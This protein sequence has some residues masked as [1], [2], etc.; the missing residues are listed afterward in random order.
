MRYL[1]ALLC[2]LG[3]V[4]LMAGPNKARMGGSIA[5]VIAGSLVMA[6]V[7]GVILYRTF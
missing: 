6:L 7:F 1:P 4:V 5:L 2:A 3:M